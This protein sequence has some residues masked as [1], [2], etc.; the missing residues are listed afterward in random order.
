MSWLNKKQNKSEGFN[1][2]DPPSNHFCSNWI[3]IIDFSAGVTLKFDGWPRKI[4]GHLFYTTSSFVH[5]FKSIG[6]FKL[7]LQSRNP[8]LRSKS[9]NCVPCD[10][11]IWWT[12]LK[13]TIGLLF[14]ATF[15]FVS[16]F[17]NIGEFKPEVTVRKR[18]IR[19]KSAIFVVPYDFE[20]WRM[21]LKNN[22]T[23]PLCCFKLWVSFHSH[24]WI[25]TG[26]TGRKRPIWVK[27][28][29]FPMLAWNL[30]VD[31]FYATYSFIHRPIA[32]GEFKLESQ[33]GNTQFGS[34]W[35]FFLAVRLWNLKDCLEKQ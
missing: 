3:Q 27:I 17:Q 32:I 1:S 4:K 23:P 26:V 25:L 35:W 28:C 29:F 9:A 11:E 30:T 16:S 13:K 5:H 24:Q 20:I 18:S 19:A 31:L 22:S 34:N 12:I 10:L 2:C 15:S 6:E 8:Q 21:T 7:E 33:S 14:Y